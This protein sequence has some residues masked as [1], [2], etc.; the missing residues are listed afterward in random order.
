MQTKQIS[1]VETVKTEC[2]ETIK[3]FI[4]QSPL[5]RDLMDEFYCFFQQDKYEDTVWEYNYYTVLLLQALANPNVNSEITKIVGA[6]SMEDILEMLSRLQCLAATCDDHYREVF[7]LHELSKYS[8]LNANTMEE[9]EKITKKY[10]RKIEAGKI[11]K[12]L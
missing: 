6:S 2:L 10:E 12:G 4:D 5:S 3:E 7:E 9:W 11:L 8:N 1:T